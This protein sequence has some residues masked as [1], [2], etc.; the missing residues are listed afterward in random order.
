MRIQEI[1]E[2]RGMM[3]KELAAKLKIKPNRLSQYE[4]GVTEPDINM[5][6]EIANALE[7]TVDHL[8]ENDTKNTET[9]DNIKIP[10]LGKVIAG[11]PMDAVE[12]ILDWEEIPRKW[13]RDGSE[14]FALQIYGDSMEPKMSEGDIVIV[15]KQPDIENGEI[16]VVLVDGERATVK[17]V[18]K[19][20]TGVF[21]MP[22]NTS[23]EPLFFTNKE[24]EMLPVVV[25]GKVIELRRK[26]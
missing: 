5:L 13:G 25:L 26:F 6:K 8:I 4:T 22:V 12:E 21:L 3:Q 7:V 15:R 9:G 11:V 14:F 10:V 24:V 20:K 19:Q 17:I 2:K 18:K 16:A 23:Y 1:R